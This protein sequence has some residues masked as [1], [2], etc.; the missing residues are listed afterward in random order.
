MIQPRLIINLFDMMTIRPLKPDDK[1]EIIRLHKTLFFPEFSEDEL[2]HEAA[3]MLR[4]DPN[5]WMTI[6]AE[7]K[8][9]K[10]CG[11]ICGS[12]RQET[13]IIGRIK[14]GYVEAWYIE[15][16]KQQQGIGTALY[17]TLEQW[18]LQQGCDIAKS[19]TDLQN[20]ASI[21]AHKRQGFAVSDR[22][23]KFTKKLGDAH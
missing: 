21:N 12:I 22:I 1:N 5:Y 4:A 17:Q 3:D 6:V 7:E 9:G 10:L 23:V 11:Y 14:V 8:P 18:F 16:D 20:D 13:P 2:K 15:P 19:D